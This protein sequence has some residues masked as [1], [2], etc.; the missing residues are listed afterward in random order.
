MSETTSW[1]VSSWYISL[2]NYT[3]PTVF[4][5]LNEKEKEAYLNK[6][7]NSAAAKGLIGKFDYVIEHLPGSSF[8]HADSCA[9]T[10]S[11]TFKNTDGAVKKGRQVWNILS[12][13]EKVRK[14]IESGETERFCLHPFRR[15]DHSREFRLF[16]YEGELKGMSQRFLDSYVS[17]IQK[18]QDEIWKM[19]QKLLIGISDF[20]PAENIVVDVYLTATDRLMILDLNPWEA[21][22]PLLFRWDI[23]WNESQGLKLVP[24]PM[25]LGG[26]VSVSF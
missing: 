15:M 2:A 13:S 7:G 9:P 11:E 10:D 16:V 1:P 23:D 26:D 20:L 3:F 17:R 19:G 5:R 12:E 18:R 14:A 4:I 21:C 6:K 25:Q 8:I 22:D 24:K